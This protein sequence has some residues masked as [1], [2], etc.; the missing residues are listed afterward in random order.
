[1]A[2]KSRYMIV[3]AMKNEGPYILDWVA[4]HMSLG[5]DH[6]L[7]VTNDCNDGT[8]RILDRLAELGH[9]THVPNPKML[10]RNE[11]QWQVMALRYAKLFNVYRDA[12]W[13]FHSDVDEFLQV[14]LP[15][16]TLGAF[17]KQVGECD[18]VSMTSVPYN[19]N[20][21]KSLCDEPA[22]SLFRQRNKP[23]GALSE[24]GRP[25]L[26]AVKTLYRNSVP[27]QLRRNHRPLMESFSKDGYVWR[28]GSGNVLPPSYTDTQ[29]K[30][31]D[32]LSSVRYAQLNHYA[33]RCA[34]AYLIKVNRGDVASTT[35]LQKSLKYWNSY[36]TQGDEDLRYVTPSPL[37]RQIRADFANDPELTDWH[38]R[39]VIF[40]HEMAARILETEEGRALAEKIGYFG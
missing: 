12:E 15:E 22:P 18:A 29:I 26:N 10:R 36:N 9:V 5:F 21:Q 24:E 7:V 14:N 30:A 3:T 20:G 23:Y 8:D 28:D 31:L 39:A 19:S 13:I 1:M 2:K 34:E 40:H 25:V 32:A 37:A 11:G 38:N 35:R 4:H 27:F 16:K 6:F 17:L 33:I